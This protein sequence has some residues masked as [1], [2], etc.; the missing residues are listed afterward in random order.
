MQTKKQTFTRTST[1]H[2]SLIVSILYEQA[3]RPQP[4]Q[5]L[6]VLLDNIQVWVIHPCCI[7]H[8]FWITV[9][10]N[11]C[12]SCWPCTQPG[13]PRA[14]D[15]HIPSCPPACASG[16]T[17]QPYSQGTNSDLVSRGENLQKVGC[18]GQHERDYVDAAFA[19]LVVGLG[20]NTSSMLETMSIVVSVLPGWK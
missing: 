14:F 5:W 9:F 17:P 7:S 8:I 3:K 1:C 13:S 4:E 12:S 10:T 6:A 19:W 20:K 18:G 15:K 16:T 2:A 11:H